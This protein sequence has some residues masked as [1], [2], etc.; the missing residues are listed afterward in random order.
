MKKT[1]LLVTLFF[2]YF[3]LIIIFK[4]TVADKPIPEIIGRIND[5]ADMLTSYEE[6]EIERLL[7][8]NEK[9]TSNQIVVVTIDTLGGDGLE[10][11]S[12]RL[13]ESWKIGQKEKGNGV[14]LLI[15]KQERKLRIEVGY[16]LECALPDGLC[17]SIIRDKIAPSFKEGDYFH[18]IKNGVNA[19]I[20]ATRGEY[21]TQITIH[22]ISD[23][24]TMHDVSDSLLTWLAILCTLAGAFT[25]PMF[26]W[27]YKTFHHFVTSAVK[28]KKDKSGFNP[29][30]HVIGPLIIVVIYFVFVRIL[31]M[32]P[33]ENLINKIIFLYALCL[34][35]GG[36]ITLGILT[37]VFN[38]DES[39]T[40]SSKGYQSRKKFKDNW[41]RSFNDFYYRDS[42]DFGSG[43]GGFSGGGGG[44]SSGG[45]GFSG[46]GGSFGGGGASGSW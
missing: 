30:L 27:I 32:N 11:Y 39:S 43:G 22:D 23:Q 3:V 29:L 12:I 36:L 13:A 45:G 46:G 26:V 6:I 19:I 33:I 5:F 9:A 1:K 16:G 2:I 8:E 17:G 10:D 28:N 4:T 44:F 14:I 41:S 25:F 18:G 40:Y 42:G 21:I 15:S 38:I 37:G 20:K 34:F 7:E 35:F 31:I 24:K